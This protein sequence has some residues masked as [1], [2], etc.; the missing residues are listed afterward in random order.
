MWKLRNADTPPRRIRLMVGMLKLETDVAAEPSLQRNLCEQIRQQQAVPLPGAAGPDRRCPEA[1][2]ARD[3]H[4]LT[5]GEL[6]V[7]M[8]S[9]EVTVAGMRVEVST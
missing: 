1:R 9:R 2:G 8:L 7:N 5:Y 4:R 3:A 6:V